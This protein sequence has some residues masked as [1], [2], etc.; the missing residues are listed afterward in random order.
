MAAT[1]DPAS[2]LREARK[3]Y[4]AVNRFGDNGGYDERWVQVKLGPVPFAIP[5]TASRVRA[6]KVHDLHH[7]LTGYQTDIVGEFEISAW[8]IAAGCKDFYAAWVLNLSG[9]TGGMLVAPR[10]IARAFARGLASTS[11]YGRPLDELLDLKGGEARARFVHPAGTPARLGV[12][13]AAQLALATAAGAVVGTTMMVAL[14]PLLPF[15]LLARR[16]AELK[17]TPA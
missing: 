12:K 11:L 4:F 8:E 9:I 7:I 1:Y 16:Q 10:R 5:N 6:V 13:G 3:H 14:L 17:A 2:T 15:G